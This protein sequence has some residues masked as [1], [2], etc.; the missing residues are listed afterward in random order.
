MIF[1]DLTGDWYSG[2]EGLQGARDP[3]I[4]IISDPTPFFL[5]LVGA[6]TNYDSLPL[7]YKY[8]A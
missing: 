3:G 6:C 1:P 5:A 4:R 8:T 7:C 2:R